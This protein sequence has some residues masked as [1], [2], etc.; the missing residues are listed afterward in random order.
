[1][2][3]GEIVQSTGQRVLFFYSRPFKGTGRSYKALEIS[4]VKCKLI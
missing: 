4:K 2:Q 3:Q 1:M